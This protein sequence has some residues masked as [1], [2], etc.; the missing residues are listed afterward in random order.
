MAEAVAAPETKGWWTRLVEFYHG[1][2]A[3]MKKVT[4]PDAQQVRSA[5]IAIII[6]VLLLGAF[7]SILDLVLQGILIKGIPTLISGGR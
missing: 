6:F 4:W 2:M 5:T 3:E 7:I 1:V